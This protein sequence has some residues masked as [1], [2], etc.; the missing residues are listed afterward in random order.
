MV[1]AAEDPNFRKS[2]PTDVALI[3][4]MIALLGSMIAVIKSTT[5]RAHFVFQKRHGITTE[6]PRVVIES[7]AHRESVVSVDNEGVRH[8]NIVQFEVF[9]I[10]GEP[11]DEDDPRAA[12]AFREVQAARVQGVIAELAFIGVPG[13]DQVLQNWKAAI[14]NPDVAPP[15]GVP[16]A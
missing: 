11:A 10:S 14:A 3:N 8:V 16:T 2:S 4:Q 9:G 6:P 13:F 12:K 15:G 5:D 1:A 7:F